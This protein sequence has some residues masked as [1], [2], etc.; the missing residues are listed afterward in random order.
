MLNKENLHKIY[1]LF[2]AVIVAYGVFLGLTDG[3]SFRILSLRMYTYQSNALMVI[4]CFLMFA[5]YHKKTP[6]KYYI[7]S[8]V[9]LAITVTGLVYNFVLVP[10]SGYNMFYSSYINF[11]THFLAPAL[12]LINYFV[13]EQKG[14]LN[15]KHVLA[16]MIY[17][18]VYWVIFISIGGQIQFYPYFFMNPER[19]GWPMVFVWFGIL[20]SAFFILGVLLVIYDKKMTQNK[21]DG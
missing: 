18:A 12:A 2:C 7:S 21:I 15:F 4:G 14:Y 19:V 13:F 9:L 1:L 10:F 17:P 3:G 5:L 11:T 6:L 8:S 20:L 16:G